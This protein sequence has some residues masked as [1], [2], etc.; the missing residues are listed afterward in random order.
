[1]EKVVLD[2]TLGA[3]LR[4]LDGEAELCDESGRKLGVFLTPDAYMRLLYDAAKG[5]FSDEETAQAREDYRKNGGV[6]TAELL[7]HLRSL[8]NQPGGA[9]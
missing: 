3:K 7:A 8:D 2:P 1:M 6:T 5:W 9:S 4:D